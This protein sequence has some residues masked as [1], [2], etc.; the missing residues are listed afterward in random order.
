M[1]PKI[2]ANMAIIPKND[3]W[4]RP[5]LSIK[6][7]KEP[8]NIPIMEPNAPITIS[9]VLERVL[10]RF[11]LISMDCHIIYNIINR[12]WPEAHNVRFF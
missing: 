8:E 6:I 1:K 3:M 9:K 4:A 10:V 7:R 2:E 5:K 11:I 12:Q